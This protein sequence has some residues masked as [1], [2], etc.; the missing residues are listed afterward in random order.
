MHWIENNKVFIERE[1]DKLIPRLRESHNRW[2][3][4][5]GGGGG[6]RLFGEIV[7]V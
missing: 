1:R 5:G 4:G 6:V 2:G 3:G 7:A